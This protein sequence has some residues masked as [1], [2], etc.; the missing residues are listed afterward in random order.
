MELITVNKTDPL[1][2]WVNDHPVIIPFCDAVLVEDEIAFDLAEEWHTDLKFLKFVRDY[3]YMV[4]LPKRL[5]TPIVWAAAKI[6]LV[7]SCQS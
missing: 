1:G 6:G 3:D 5:Q 4:Y 7:W 2:I